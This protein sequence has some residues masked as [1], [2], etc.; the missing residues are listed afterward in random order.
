[1][2]VMVATMTVLTSGIETGG[3]MRRAMR[4]APAGRD[5]SNDL[6]RLAVVVAVA[7]GL[8]ALIGVAIVAIVVVGGLLPALVAAIAPDLE[9]FLGVAVVPLVVLPPAALIAGPTVIDR[10]NARRTGR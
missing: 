9:P 5:G 1:M 3:R 7:F 8:G 4:H 2:K 6:A 10:I